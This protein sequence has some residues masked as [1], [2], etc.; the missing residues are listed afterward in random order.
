MRSQFTL[1]QNQAKSAIEVAL[2]AN[3]PLFLQGQ[4][5]IGKSAIIKAI[6][7]KYNLK[8]IDIRLSQISQFDLN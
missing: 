1:S 4:A 3:T 7:K 8:V 5:G 6:G 2:K